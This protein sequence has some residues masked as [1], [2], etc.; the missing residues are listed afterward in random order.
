MNNNDEICKLFK[1]KFPGMISRER[2]ISSVI[3]QH[4]IIKN[5][6]TSIAFF[7]LEL[8][9]ENPDNP[10]FKDVPEAQLAPLRV[11]RIKRISERRKV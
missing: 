5:Q 7:T 4:S 10:F 3:K 1:V 2:L 6:E 11:I 8:F 9:C